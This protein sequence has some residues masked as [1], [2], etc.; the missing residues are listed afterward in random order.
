MLSSK[1]RGLG[2]GK[3]F[4]KEANHFFLV[5]VL[6]SQLVLPFPL[7]AAENEGPGPTPDGSEAE[8]SGTSAAGSL[9]GLEQLLGDDSLPGEQHLHPE[10][11]AKL[12]ARLQ[13]VTKQINNA[14]SMASRL[15][16]T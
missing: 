6:I 2:K 16:L 12:E 4:L 7:L 11:V 14:P 8:V 1:A 15:A 13:H 10:D 5:F 3:C 9:P